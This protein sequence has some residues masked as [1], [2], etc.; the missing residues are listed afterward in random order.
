MVDE[1]SFIPIFPIPVTTD[2]LCYF[3]LGGISE[4]RLSSLYKLSSNE[5]SS[6]L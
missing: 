1:I 4:P 5:E 2:S 3:T 6:E